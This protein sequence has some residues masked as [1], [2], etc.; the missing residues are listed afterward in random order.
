[1]AAVILEWD[2]RR[3]EFWDYRAAVERVA[4]SGR[5]LQRWEVGPGWDILPEAEVWLVLHGASEAAAGLAGHGVVMSGPYTISPH[6][7]RGLGGTFITVAFDALLPLGEQVRPA[8]LREAIP[9]IHWNHGAAGSPGSAGAIMAVPESA[10]SGLRRLWRDHAP[11]RYRT[12]R[13]VPGA[14][15][16]EAVTSAV[17]NQYEQDPDARRLC[18]AFHGT[19]C[20]ACGFSFEDSFGQ[21]G[22]DGI[23]VHHVVPPALLGPGYQLDAVADLVPLCPNCHTVAH[24]GRGTPRSV[25]ELRNILSAS[26]HLRG[27]VVRQEILD[28][29]EEAR[30]MLGGGH[31]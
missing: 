29:E 28:A 14:Y 2:T 16:P 1:M 30:R 25:S 10:E 20:A 15:P 13:L 27:Q 18:L 23:D 4:L 22:P 9:A 12:P 6:G 7:D 21:A 5:M 31:G 24:Q 3:W 19:S 26:G 8:S 17:V 11:L